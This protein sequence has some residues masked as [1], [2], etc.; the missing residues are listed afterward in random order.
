M[1]NVQTDIFNNNWPKVVRFK[2]KKRWGK[3]RKIDVPVANIHELKRAM[4][5][6]ETFGDTV[7]LIGI[8][9]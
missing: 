9:Q 7:Q 4:D 3:W 1:N 2:M 6:L 5:K 8:G